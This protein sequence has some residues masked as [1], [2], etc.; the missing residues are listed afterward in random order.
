MGQNSNETN[1]V[2]CV[3]GCGA[4]CALTCLGDATLPVLDF[5][6]IMLGTAASFE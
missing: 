3:I 5:S 1:S 4:S 2:G 6:G